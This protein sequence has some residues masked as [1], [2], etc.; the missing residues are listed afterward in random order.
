MKI[1]RELANSAR[2]D[3]TMYKC[4][5]ICIGK[6]SIFFPEI[7]CIYMLTVRWLHFL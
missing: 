7:V 2:F 3:Y 1:W 4:S 5:S 6:V